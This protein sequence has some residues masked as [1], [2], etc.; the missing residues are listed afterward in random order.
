MWQTPPQPHPQRVPTWRT[1]SAIKNADSFF[2]YSTR[3]QTTYI[4]FSWRC[5]IKCMCVYMQEAGERVT[6]YLANFIDPL[7]RT[8][9]LARMVQ[10]YL[11]FG[12]NKRTV[13]MYSP[14]T[15]RRAPV[16]I[17]GVLSCSSRY[18]IYYDSH[19]KGI[20]VSHV[21]YFYIRQSIELILCFCALANVRIGMMGA[22][23][24]KGEGKKE[25]NTGNKLVYDSFV[26]TNLFFIGISDVYDV[27]DNFDIRAG[28]L[29]LRN[30]Q[31]C[32]NSSYVLIYRRRI[33]R[34][35]VYGLR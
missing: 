17:E 12:V 34:T 11:Y 13:V 20:F 31:R 5:T 30:F 21:Q 22:E 10:Y 16:R 4:K 19:S 28:Y 2:L 25:P 15:E 6:D 33:C 32:K 18:F 35:Y 9:S 23:R 14:P 29:C 3:M 1:W 8:Y 26:R 7:I 27:R 24:G